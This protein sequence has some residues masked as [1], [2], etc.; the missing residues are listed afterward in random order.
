ML[1]PSAKGSDPA[2]GRIARTARAT[3][4]AL[5]T[6]NFRLFFVGQTISN[7]GNWLTR[8]ALILL[9]LSLTGSGLA[10]GFVTA[11]E[12]GPVLFLSAWGGAI[13]D[14][15]DKRLLLFVT[16]ALEMLQSLALAAVAAL[17]H[18][19]VSALYV[20]AVIGGAL[21]AFDNPLR[22]SFVTEMVPSEDIPNAVVLYS[23]MVNLSRVFGPALAGLLVTTLGYAAAFAIDAV[24]YLAVLVCLFMMRPQE[25]Y[26]EAGRARG[27]TSVRE[28][29]AY[30]FTQPR[31]WTSFAMLTAIG[32]FSY[33]FN[34]TLPLFVE[35]TLGSTT[36][37]FTV[38]YSIFSA[39]S[40]IGGLVVANRRFVQIRHIVAGALLM[41][42][43]LFGLA[44]APG[45]A[46]AGVV[47]FLSGMA[48][49][50]YMTATTAIIQ[51]EARRDMHGRVLALQTVIMGGTRLFGGPLLG[52]FAD[53]AGGRMPFV[54]G[55]AACL[56]AAA[57]GFLANRA[58][59]T[60]AASGSEPRSRP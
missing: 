3:F 25:L 1:M 15:S 14:R 43:T 51:V 53:L 5:R 45:V 46:T 48:T 56:I 8:V 41:G 42:I 54:I 4:L 9:V 57:F 49:I 13:A 19:P 47:I 2:G 40:V 20:L 60:I 50:L 38:L 30:V 55:G 23:T 58:D 27:R 7:T 52:W 31:L 59:R 17:P 39:G 34:V 36:T 29:I 37:V 6:R 18:P 21:L 22:R 10:V 26:R 44:F 35:D 11:C 16:Q 28:A 32:I 12:F 33:N 24:S